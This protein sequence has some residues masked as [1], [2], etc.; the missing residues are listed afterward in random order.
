MLWRIALTFLLLIAPINRG[1]ELDAAFMKGV[2]VSAQTWGSE[3]ATPAM[4]A[5]LDELK[6]LGVEWIAIHPYA[7]IAEDG[8]LKFDPIAEQPC[9]STPLEWARGRGM[10]V[11]LVPQIAYWGTKF[12]WRGEIN[13]DKP[14]QW[15][16]F[17]SDYEKWI[18]LQAGIAQA[19]HAEVFCIGLE[20]GYAQKFD[21]R[22]RAIIRSIRCAFR[23]K[24]TYGANWNEIENVPFWDAVDYIGTLAYFP[25]TD[26]IDPTP[27]Q[28]GEGWNPWMGKLEALSKK[29]GKPVLFTEIGYNESARCASKPWAFPTGGPNAKEIQARCIEQAL[30][31]PAHHPFLAGMFFWKWFPDLPFPEPETFDMRTPLIKHLLAKHWLSARASNE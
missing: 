1:D 7:Q 24:I 12:L 29:Y 16:R 27:K 22:W 26:A 15:A 23:G 2:T 11:M 28:I 5:A 9:V 10:R 13:F 20:Y 19:H 4:A 25:L 17:F 8:S 21:E 14:E 30:L 3:W 31:L 6:S 18:V